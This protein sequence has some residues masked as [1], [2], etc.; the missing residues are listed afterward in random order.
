MQYNIFIFL[1]YEHKE[2]HIDSL[3]LQC[4]IKLTEWGT[5]AVG[6]ITKKVMGDQQKLLTPKVCWVPFVNKLSNK[7]QKTFWF[8]IGYKTFILNRKFNQIYLSSRRQMPRKCKSQ[9][10]PRFSYFN[11]DCG[12]QSFDGQ[13]SCSKGNS[14]I[15]TASISRRTE[16]ASCRFMALC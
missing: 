7:K 2:R 14:E 1:L 6:Y 8:I 5:F 9:H 15:F 11:S 16:K 10:R 12:K 4:S 13:A 3:G